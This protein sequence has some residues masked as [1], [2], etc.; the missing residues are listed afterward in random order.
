MKFLRIAAD[1]KGP[2]RLLNPANKFGMTP[3]DDDVDERKSKFTL[4]LS[5]SLPTSYSFSISIGLEK[6]LT[7]DDDH[8]NYSMRRFATHN[9]I[10]IFDETF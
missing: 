10:I 4:K 5:V 1:T 7:R 6:R 8:A 2:Q 9:Y 3:P